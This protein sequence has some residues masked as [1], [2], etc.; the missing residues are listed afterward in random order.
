MQLIESHSGTTNTEGLAPSEDLGS[1][2]PSRFLNLIS[3]FLLR[4]NS[5][6][7]LS[8]VFCSPLSS[9]S[10][11]STP[12]DFP[13]SGYF[14]IILDMTDDIPRGG[15]PPD[16]EMDPGVE[17]LP[18]SERPFDP[19]T[20]RPAIRVLPPDGLRQFRSFDRHVPPK[21]LL[22][23]PTSH[24]SFGAS[25]FTIS[26]PAPGICLNLLNLH[27]CYICPE[28]PE[29]ADTSRVVVHWVIQSPL[30]LTWTS[31]LPLRSICLVRCHL[32]PVQALFV[33]PGSRCS[34]G[35]SPR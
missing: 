35:S 11:R 8:R 1:P 29:H 34:S 26:T 4:R 14:L 20:Y 15:T 10:S 7:S 19:A 6:P 22:R 28:P 24:L 9:V 27:V 17:L 3:H 5:T 16:H 33:T 18:L 31:G 2:R 30:I 21:L 12:P 32:S 13:P 25:E 23:E